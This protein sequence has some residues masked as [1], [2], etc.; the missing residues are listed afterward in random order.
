MT[1]QSLFVGAGV[2]AKALLVMAGTAAVVGGTSGADMRK[3]YRGLLES[4]GMAPRMV[5]ARA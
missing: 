4:E 1:R 3:E 2:P 5:I